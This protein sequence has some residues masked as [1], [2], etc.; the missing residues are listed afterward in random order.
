MATLIK[1]NRNPNYT[2]PASGTMMLWR[3]QESALPL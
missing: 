3:L 1:I 2:R